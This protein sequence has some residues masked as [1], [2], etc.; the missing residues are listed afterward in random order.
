MGEIE[1]PDLP[2]PEWKIFV[3]HPERLA[4][5]LNGEIHW[6]LRRVGTAYRGQVAFAASGSHHLWGRGFLAAVD[7]MTHDE[8]K[9]PENLQHHQE[10]RPLNVYGLESVW[11]WKFEGVVRFK[12]PIKC[13]P[14]IGA[15]TWRKMPPNVKMLVETSECI[16]KPYVWL[17]HKIAEEIMTIKSARDKKNHQ[18]SKEEAKAQSSNVKK[19]HLKKQK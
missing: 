18:K 7:R 8:L 6:L 1:V 13:E 12:D 5:L 4:N 16:E 14:A 11:T 9:L 3:V 19:H 2:D 17:F 10:P 15:S